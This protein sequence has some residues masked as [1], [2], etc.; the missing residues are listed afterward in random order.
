MIKYIYKDYYYRFNNKFNFKNNNILPIK[1]NKKAKEL[2]VIT[3]GFTGEHG[4]EL[5]NLCDY[6]IQVPSNDTP[7]IQECHILFGH[8]LC[9]IIEGELFQQ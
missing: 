2:G 9:E 3:I 4:G 6:C 8:I 5:K 7:R 1:A